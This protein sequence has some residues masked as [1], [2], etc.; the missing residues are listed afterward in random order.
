L[1]A[2]SS[3]SGTGS[4]FLSNLGFCS[5]CSLHPRLYKLVAVGDMKEMEL[6][7][8]QSKHEEIK[9]KVAQLGRFL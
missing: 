1:F 9:N 4:I 3:P 7:E 6:Q 2:C 8:L 5:P